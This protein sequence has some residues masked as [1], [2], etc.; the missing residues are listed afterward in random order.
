MI[1]QHNVIVQGNNCNILLKI[2]KYIKVVF[3]P[4]QDIALHVKKTSDNNG[5]L[6]LIH[7]S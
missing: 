5:L 4:E 7:F 3:T 2:V 6:I 1:R